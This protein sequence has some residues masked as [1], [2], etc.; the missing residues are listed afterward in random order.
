MSR[1]KYKQL[2]ELLIDE[3]ESEGFVQVIES[4]G[5]KPQILKHDRTASLKNLVSGWKIVT[6]IYP[7]TET[8]IDLRSVRDSL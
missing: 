8:K 7:E 1:Q 2:I 6:E 3:I 4:F 5:D